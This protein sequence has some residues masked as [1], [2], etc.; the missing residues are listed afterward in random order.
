MLRSILSLMLI[1][2]CSRAL[3]ISDKVVLEAGD[4]RIL[5][6][7][8]GSTVDVSPKKILEIEA[9]GKGQIRILA[10][11]S[12]IALLK[13][14]SESTE[15]TYLIEVLS[16]DSQ[17]DWLQRAEWRN[18]FCSKEGIR[19]DL[20]N[21][22]IE[23]KTNDVAWFFEARKIC[24]SKMPCGWAVRISEI[25]RLKAQN[26]LKSLYENLKV[27]LSDEAQVRIESLCE[28]KDKKS[29]EQAVLNL[30]QTYDVIPQVQCLPHTPDLW[31][32]DVLVVAERVGSGEVSNPLRWETI[33]IPSD[34]PFQAF[35][36]ELSQN[37]R[38]RI[39]ANPEVALSLGGTA[40]LKD[41]QEIQTLAIQR[42]AEE[43]L[44]K[45]SG[46]R[47]ELK[48]H[49]MREGLARVS[50]HLNLS[51]PQAGLRTIDSSEFASELWLQKE[52]LLRIG[53]LQATLEGNEETKI[54]W[55][56]EIPL[57]GQLFRWQS[58]TKA[59]SQVDVLMRI[60]PGAL[61]AEPRDTA[62]LSETES[63]SLSPVSP[64][65]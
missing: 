5:D 36:A 29:L 10:L 51:Q 54:P 61:S 40:I 32:L 37:T 11:K 22:V 17:G 2:F 56:S 13:A 55:L 19:C 49:E 31:A 65:E 41:G 60:R 44:W 43:I 33:K 59:R 58:D 30:K 3:A 27:Y 64:V 50:V 18:Y 6:I 23:G 15:K 47:L 39:I 34:K 4:S 52:Q 9:A 8:S 26:D 25:A 7:P 38:L 16:R 48:L 28:D 62:D 1:L 53:R 12:G 45:Q 63:V 42:D 21:K 20:E 35:V 24:K 14:S 46:F 57:L